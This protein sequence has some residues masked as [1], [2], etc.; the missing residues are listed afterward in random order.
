MSQKITIEIPDEL[1]ERRWYIFAGLE[2]MYIRQ[3]DGKVYKKTTRCNRCGKCCRDPGPYFPT[4]KP[5]VPEA[6][7]HDYC[8][9]CDFGGVEGWLCTNPSVPFGCK[10]DAVGKLP[11]S[12]CVITFEEI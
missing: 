8:A 3:P 9:F 7:G 6:E 11:H 4:Y 5:D 10:K 2:C 12:E 1:M